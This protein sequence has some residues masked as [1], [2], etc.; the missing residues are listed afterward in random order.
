MSAHGKPKEPEHQ[1]EQLKKLMALLR[2]GAS[3]ESTTMNAQS[4]K[5]YEAILKQRSDGLSDREFFDDLDTAKRWLFRCWA[6]LCIPLDMVDSHCAAA[7]YDHHEA[8]KRIFTMGAL[9]LLLDR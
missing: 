9:H 8:H 5:R 6:E 4:G 7:I 3:N 2:I 1:S